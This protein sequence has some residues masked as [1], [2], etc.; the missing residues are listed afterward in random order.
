MA[1]AKQIIV[2]LLVVLAVLAQ[3]SFGKLPPSSTCASGNLTYLACVAGRRRK[4][5]AF[6]QEDNAQGTQTAIISRQIL[7]PLSGTR[8]GRKKK[9]AVVLKAFYEEY[10]PGASHVACLFPKRKAKTPTACYA[11]CKAGFEPTKPRLG[12][13]LVLT[14]KKRKNLWQTDSGCIGE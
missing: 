12:Y 9:T 3:P 14:C 2:V 6:L 8:C 10:H 1:L 7:S 13:G 4:N 5:R 11:N